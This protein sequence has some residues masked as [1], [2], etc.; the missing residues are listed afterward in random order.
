MIPLLSSRGFTE[1][2][3][4]YVVFFHSDH[5]FLQPKQQDFCAACPW[6]QA[7]PTC[8]HHPWPLF[9]PLPAVPADLTRRYRAT[10]VSISSYGVNIS[11]WWVSQEGW[12]PNVVSLGLIHLLVHEHLVLSELSEG[13]SP[14]ASRRERVSQRSSQ[15]YTTSAGIS[16]IL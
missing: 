10:Y 2:G 12:N 8:L 6:S 16:Q 13:T 15:I 1:G 3:P 7:T 5:V 4:C 9:T 11:D 14:A